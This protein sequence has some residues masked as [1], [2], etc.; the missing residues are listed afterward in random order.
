[1]AFW[2]TFS[3]STTFILSEHMRVVTHLGLFLSHTLL[4][5]LITVP[6]ALQL[7]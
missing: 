2:P 5:E 1:M 4:N 6:L 3:N 7:P